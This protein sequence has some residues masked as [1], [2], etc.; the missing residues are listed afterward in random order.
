M[1][2]IFHSGWVILSFLQVRFVGKN[3]EEEDSSSGFFLANLYW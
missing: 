1:D 2:F 3:A